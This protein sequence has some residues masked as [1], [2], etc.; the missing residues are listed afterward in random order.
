MVVFWFL[1][2][3]CLFVFWVGFCFLVVF[4][5]LFGCVLVVCLFKLYVG[6]C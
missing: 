4:C 5:A 1:F 6:L 3:R 2:F